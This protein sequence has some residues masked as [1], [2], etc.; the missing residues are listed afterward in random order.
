MHCRSNK[1]QT[2]KKQKNKK[3]HNVNTPSTR[4]RMIAQF[5]AVFV[6]VAQFVGITSTMLKG[7]FFLHLFFFICFLAV[8]IPLVSVVTVPTFNF[9]ANFV[10]TTCSVV[11]ATTE[12]QGTDSRALVLVSVPIVSALTYVS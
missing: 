5:S 12:Y 9:N 7:R 1:G 11:N 2:A 3:T 6:A 8:F 4:P 10:N